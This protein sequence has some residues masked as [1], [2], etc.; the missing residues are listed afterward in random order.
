MRWKADWSVCCTN[1]KKLSYRRDS[2]RLR[3]LRRSRSCKV[4]EFGTRHISRKRQL[5]VSEIIGGFLFLP[6]FPL[7]PLSL[8]HI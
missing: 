5:G 1:N 3:S 6:P 4:T 8:I 2:E 7:L